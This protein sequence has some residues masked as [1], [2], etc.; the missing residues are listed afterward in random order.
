[1]LV[2][3]P[4]N[5]YMLFE[6]IIAIPEYF[7]SKIPYID[8]FLMKIQISKKNEAYVKGVYFNIVLSSKK[9]LIY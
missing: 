7:S 3:L 1:M 2:N 5:F 4:L 6:N 8:N 9:I